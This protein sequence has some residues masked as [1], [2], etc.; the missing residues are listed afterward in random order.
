[1]KHYGALAGGLADPWFAEHGYT[2]ILHCG[3]WI[4]VWVGG[5]AQ[6]VTEDPSPKKP[7]PHHL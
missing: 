7:P 1:V 2:V 5:A 6:A 4:R 3:Q